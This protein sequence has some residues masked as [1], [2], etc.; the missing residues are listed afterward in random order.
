MGDKYYSLTTQGQGS[1]R[2]YIKGLSVLPW[3][4]L[5]CSLACEPHTHLSAG[6]TAASRQ[7]PQGLR[8]VSISPQPRQ[9]LCES[10]ALAGLRAHTHVQS[11]THIHICTHIHACFQTPTHTHMH[12]RTRVFKHMHT[13]T[14]VHLYTIRVHAHAHVHAHTHTAWARDLEP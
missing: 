14:H 9:R 11:Q 12:T 7:H 8:S 10:R 2:P 6:K 13:Y 1:T 3:R 5:A 4:G